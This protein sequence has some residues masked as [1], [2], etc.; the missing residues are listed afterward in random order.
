MK[1]RISTFI[2]FLLM[3]NLVVFSQKSIKYRTPDGII[4]CRLDKHP[5]LIHQNLGGR[6]SLILH[7]VYCENDQSTK[8]ISYYQYESKASDVLDAAR[9]EKIISEAGEKFSKSMKLKIE[10]REHIKWLKEDC[11]ETVAYDN[12][13]GVV[14]R[15]LM[16]DNYIIQVVFSK[17]F[18]LPSKK[19]LNYFFD[20]IK[21]RT[22]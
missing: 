3:T 21:I 19:E 2:L 8:M 20:R 16:K 6:D 15:I 22:N 9:K 1:Y 7:I 18:G 12:N 17:P 10:R 14:H 5:D 13:S 11:I 4:T